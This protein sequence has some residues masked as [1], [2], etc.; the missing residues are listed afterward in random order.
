ML[1]PSGLPPST[2]P[3]MKMACNLK[4]KDQLIVGSVSPSRQG[5]P[6]EG[7]SIRCG[8]I[9]LDVFFLFETNTA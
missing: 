5:P 2:A 8:E 7:K 3:L 6:N 9:L 1:E 4:T